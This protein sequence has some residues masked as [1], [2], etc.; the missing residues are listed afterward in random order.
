MA[1]RMKR[2]RV[3]PV[4]GID[5]GRL[6]KTVRFGEPRYIGDPLMAIR[7]FNDK[8]VDE[9]I[10]AD[11]RASKAGRGADHELLRR[12]AGECFM[13]IGYAGGVRS[14]DDAKRIFDLGIEKVGVCSAFLERPGLVTELAASYGSQSVMVSI[15]V[16]KPLFGGLRAVGR[17]GGRSA[18]RGPVQMAREAADAGAGEILLHAVYRE[19]TFKGYDLELVAE[20]AAAVQVPVVALGGARDL[21]D[22][23]AAIG[24]GACAVAA[25]SMFVYKRNDVR[26]ILINYPSPG[27]VDQALRERSGRAPG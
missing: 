5:Q 6:V 12:M 17:S 23:V 21:N 14:V 15:D 16:D 1:A 20:V 24:A 2:V 18:K 25:S 13:P 22:L 8:E 19:G 9:L 26:S 3:I 7:I 11:I 27:A 10:I 4:L